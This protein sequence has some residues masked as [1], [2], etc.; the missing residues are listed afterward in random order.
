MSMMT[1]LMRE[2]YNIEAEIRFLRIAAMKHSRSERF[3]SFN[4]RQARPTELY[5]AG[6]IL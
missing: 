3:L 6:I 5:I 2:S 4:A 1:I